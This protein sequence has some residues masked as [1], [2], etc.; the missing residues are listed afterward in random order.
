[1]SSLGTS[2]PDSNTTVYA[3]RKFTSKLVTN[4]IDA[5]MGSGPSTGEPRGITNVVVDVKSTESMKVNSRPSISS[6][7]TGKKEVKLLGYSRN[8]QV[9]IEQDD[10]L[11]MQING[12]VAELIV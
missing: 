12:I 5:S 7:F 3:G 6:S 2:G 10:P 4:P 9:T 1:M 11:P 8:P